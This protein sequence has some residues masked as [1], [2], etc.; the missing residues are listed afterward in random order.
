MTRVNDKGFLDVLEE[1]IYK[2][3]YD[4]LI[5][6]EKPGEQIFHVGG[7]SIEKLKSQFFFLSGLI[8]SHRRDH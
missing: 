4:F 5:V 8:S 3:K 6:G 7:K 2:N 1:K